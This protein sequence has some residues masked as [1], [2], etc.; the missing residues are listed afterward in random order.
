MPRR[1]GP[2]ARPPCRS[3]SCTARRSL[4]MSWSSKCSL[5]EGR[6]HSRKTHRAPHTPEPGARRKPMGKTKRWG[7]R[8]FRDIPG[9]LPPVRGQAGDGRQKQ[10][11]AAR[12]RTGAKDC[13]AST[14]SEQGPQ[15]VFVLW[16]AP[17]CASTPSCLRVVPAS[18]PATGVG[19]SVPPPASGPPDPPRDGPPGRDCGASVRRYG[20]KRAPRADVHCRRGGVSPGP[21][22][23]RSQSPLT[24][25]ENCRDAS[26]RRPRPSTLP[27]WSNNISLY[28]PGSLR[29]RCSRARAKGSSAG[30]APEIS[31]R[32]DHASRGQAAPLRDFGR[33]AGVSTVETRPRFTD[34]ARRG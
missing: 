3:R 4:R 7:K 24:V 32:I 11:P 13:A 14:S 34:R 25:G 30:A 9:I 22:R 20:S 26:W 23:R 2:G 19:P 12:I 5:A 21:C 6:T 18:P 10:G 15:N 1:A 27:K 16:R 28:A 17:V 31:C 33:Q 8:E 29:R